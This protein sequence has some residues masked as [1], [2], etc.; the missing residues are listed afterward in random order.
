MTEMN[1]AQQFIEIAKYVS[2]IF[3]P[4]QNSLEYNTLAAKN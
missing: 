4:K 3:N 1:P 2:V